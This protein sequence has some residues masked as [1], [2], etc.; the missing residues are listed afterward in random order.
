MDPKLY[1]Y[2]INTDV[3]GAQTTR[4]GTEFR[5]SEFGSERLTSVSLSHL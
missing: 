3:L 5:S 1:Q 2:V 4:Q